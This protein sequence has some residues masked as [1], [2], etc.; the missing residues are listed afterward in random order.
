[1]HMTFGRLGAVDRQAKMSGMEGALPA[2]RT[3]RLPLWR[4]ANLLAL[5]GVVFV[6]AGIALAGYKGDAYIYWQASH[7]P[8]DLYS[9]T[10]NRDAFSYVYPPIFAQL[11]VPLGLLPY[12][13]FLALWVALETAALVWLAGPLLAFAAI[14]LYEPFQH[15][16]LTGNVNLMLAAAVVLAM[17]YPGW[18][19][20]AL[21]SK[22]TPG[23]GLLYHALRREWHYLAIACGVTAALVAASFLLA[24][25]LWF[26]W[27]GRMGASL[28]Q[29]SNPD[30]LLPLSVRLVA[31]VAVIGIGAWKGWRWTM[32]LAAG[33]AL[34]NFV[35]MNLAYFV[36]LL[37]FLADRVQ[38]ERVGSR[39]AGERVHGS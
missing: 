14:L 32:V 33:L 15:E 8:A 10:W 20:F 37:P 38:A 13:I 36:A 24:P 30:E 18:W 6:A 11:L 34:P 3:Y 29:P 39:L 22:V 2:V 26:E 31:A 17:R 25:G 9:G 4:I 7:L 12:S 23:V 16:I 35:P 21:L 28:S 1:M 19:A 27:I 5:G